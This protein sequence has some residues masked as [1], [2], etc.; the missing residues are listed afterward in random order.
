M[1]KYIMTIV[2]D[3]LIMEVSTVNVKVYAQV[4]VVSITIH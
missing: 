2:V 1:V 4:V 3:G